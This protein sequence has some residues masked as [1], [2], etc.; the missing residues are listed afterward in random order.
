MV[1]FQDTTYE[2]LPVS[3]PNSWHRPLNLISVKPQIPPPPPPSSLYCIPVFPHP[4]PPSVITPK[5]KRRSCQS[6]TQLSLSLFC[7]SHLC[8][9]VSVRAVQACSAC[10]QQGFVFERVCSLASLAF[11]S[12]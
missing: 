11:T 6:N 1:K 9:S 3:T 4:P 5:V 10:I 2:L 12:W 7:L 8:L